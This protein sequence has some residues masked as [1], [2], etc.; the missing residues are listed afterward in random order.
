MTRSIACALAVVA[1]AAGCE[2]TPSSIAA[3][4]FRGAPVILISID[5]LRADHLPAYGYGAGSTPAIDRLARSGVV[6][7]EAYSQCP[8]TLPSH[9]SLLTGRLPFHHGVRDNIGYTVADDERTLAARFKAA[10]YATGG[11]VSSYVLRHQTGIGRGFDFFDDLMEVAGTGES[12]SETQR[13]G[14]LTV[15]ALAGWVDA[16][17]DQPVFA[18]LHLY[19]PHAPYAPPPSHVMAQPYDGEIAYA[20]ELVGRFIDRL[21]ARGLFDRSILAVVSDHGEGL[22]DHG[23]AEHGL[24]LYREA[25]RVPLIVRLP[26]RQRRG[27]RIGGPV[28]LVDVAPTLLELAGASSD[29][30]DGQSLVSALTSRRAA[31]RTVYSETLYPRLH[32]G[33]SDLASAVDGRY[34]YIRAPKP[35]LYDIA[36]DPRERTSIA[37]ARR[38]TADALAAWLERT[39]AGSPV[40][41]PAKVD[42]DVRERLKALGYIGSSP[43][44]TGAAALANPKD[45][46]ASYEMLKQAEDLDRAGKPTEAIVAL[47]RLV[48]ANP[49]MLD[50]WES[51]AK[52]LARADRLPEAIDAFG[53]VLAIDPLKPETHLALARIYGL[54]RKTSRARAH[55]ELAAHRD[56]AAG[57][58]LLAELMMDERKLTDAQ[59][60][61]R[62]SLDVDASRYMSLFLLGVIAKEQGRCD[63]A[64]VE[65]QRAIEA[66]RLAPHS[67]VRSLHASLADCLARAGRQAEA[68]REFQLELETIAWSPEARVGLAMLYRSQG[69]DADARTV[70]EGLITRTPQPNAEVYWTVVRTFTV[71]GDAA[72]ARE[73]SARAREQ[74]PRDPRFR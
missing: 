39:T 59:S 7:D 26:G 62:K 10:G 30:V 66:K 24:L 52:S 12:L 13:D 9:T 73:W 11:A 3:D 27:W 46:I 4:R 58:E 40:A 14:R 31:D 23:E 20:D 34:H 53:K 44:T 50:G 72:A 15:D 55:A 36:S 45:M 57:Y 21:T 63:D 43:T 61:A 51:L 37:E 74:F 16:H 1:A 6:F 17:A 49:Q 70:L 48:A 69:R 71:L 29:G 22:G 28:G 2:R 54:Q 67:V 5:T 25:L 18:F 41:E 65:F 68:E 56:P 32:F 19:E 60:Y 42:A 35:E 47:R 64:I 8:L 38:S 33:W